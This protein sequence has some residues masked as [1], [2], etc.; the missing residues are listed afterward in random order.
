MAILSRLI[1]PNLFGMVRNISSQCDEVL[2]NHNKN[3]VVIT[4]N[5]PK[6]LNALNIPMVKEL[7]RVLKDVH[8][9]K[10]A[11]IVIVKSNN[12]K[13]FC[14]GGDVLAVSKSAKEGGEV[15]KRFFYEE[16]IVN[17]LIGTCPVPYVALIH[18]ITMGG[19]CGISIP[20][21]FRVATEKTMLAMPETALGLFPDVGGSYFLSRLKN[22]CGMF[23][24]LTGYRLKG[25]DVFHSGLATHYINSTDLA[26]LQNELLALSVANDNSVDSVLRKFQP[27]ELPAFSLEPHLRTIDKCFDGEKYEDV[28]SRLE[29]DGSDFAKSQLKELVKMSPTS[30]KVTFRQ[31]KTGSKL[32]LSDA[33]MM[34]YRL[35][36][37]ISEDHDFHEGCRAILIDK[38]RNPKWK[39]ASVSE[40][41]DDTM[42]RYFSRL[43]EERELNLQ[44]KL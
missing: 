2:I 25:A 38:D 44:A 40:V 1:R 22:N 23:L 29:K 27:N 32:S 20:G 3:K 33:L 30:L 41:S 19:G 10:T 18:G 12:D 43:P 4:L 42:D 26:S 35:S 16:Y 6:A 31:L 11:D 21:K 13:A 34:E 5:R 14:A 8:E 15:H 9:N 39:P 7:Y 17:N 36:Q 37:R 28:V 24:A